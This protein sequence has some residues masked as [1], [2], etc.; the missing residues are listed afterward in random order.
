MFTERPDSGHTSIRD[1]LSGVMRIEKKSDPASRPITLTNQFLLSFGSYVGIVKVGVGLRFLIRVIIADEPVRSTASGKRGG[2]E[3]G[4]ASMTM[5]DLGFTLELRGV[6]GGGI[7]FR[8]ISGSQRSFSSYLRIEISFLKTSSL[9]LNWLS[10]D[11][12]SRCM[13]EMIA[14]G[15]VSVFLF[16]AMVEPP[17]EVSSGIYTTSTGGRGSVFGTNWMGVLSLGRRLDLEFLDL[18][19]IEVVKRV[20]T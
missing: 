19:L 18:E 5:L 7:N 6:G 13:L 3:G 10:L 17:R 11:R 2:G 14:M 20:D 15:E 8:G 9:F 4:G 12:N 16:V 1:V